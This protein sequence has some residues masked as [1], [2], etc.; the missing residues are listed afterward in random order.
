MKVKTVNRTI[1]V[2]R[3][4]RKDNFRVKYG[5]RNSFDWL[6][7][8]ITRDRNKTII[9]QWF[10]NEELSGKDSIHF[11]TVIKSNK[12]NIRWQGVKPVKY[13]K[14]VI[15][16]LQPGWFQMGYYVYVVLIRYKGKRYYYIGMT[17][18][19]NHLT[20][21][22]PF[23]RMSGHFIIG[24]STQNQ[25]IRGIEAKIGIKVKD[26]YQ[27][28]C[29]MKFTYYSWMV[30]PFQQGVDKEIHQ[31]NRVFT[32][33]I[34]SGLIKKCLHEFGSEYVFNSK[35]SRKE[36]GGAENDINQLFKQIKKLK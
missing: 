28:L 32:E 30:R 31:S 27:A 10:K 19:R 36:I 18:D 33:K 8:N 25:T 26:N 16:E 11:S 23:Y 4:N 2:Y 34:E 15:M 29:D 24:N 17:G 14:P 1:P 7:V 6:Q 21:R 3:E 12:L 35:Q 13:G 9:T 22:S 5:D 20:A